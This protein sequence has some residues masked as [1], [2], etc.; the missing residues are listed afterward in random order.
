MTKTRYSVRWCKDGVG[1]EGECIALLSVDIPFDAMK[2]FVDS[3]WAQTWEETRWIDI[4]DMETGEVIYN[5]DN[6]DIRADN[7]DNDCG[8]DPYL[9]CFT[10]D[11]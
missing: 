9:G 10:D 4:L 8:F 3:L 1:D 7:C 11:C 6:W 5:C 2:D